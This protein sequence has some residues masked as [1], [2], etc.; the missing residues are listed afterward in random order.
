MLVPLK[1]TLSETDNFFGWAH[2]ISYETLNALL[3]NPTKC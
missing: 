2:S 3:L 1:F